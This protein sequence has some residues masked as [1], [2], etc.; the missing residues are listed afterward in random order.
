[1]HTQFRV[2]G[3]HRV[4]NSFLFILLVFLSSSCSTPPR[5]DEAGNVVGQIVKVVDGDTVQLTIG[6]KR[7]TV[8][9]IGVDTPETKHPTKPVECWGPEAAAFTESV[10]PPGT[11]VIVV[12]DEQARDKYGRLLAY[13]YRRD[14]KIFI[15]RELVSGG[16]A[17]TLTIPPNTAY[18]TVFERDR[19][20]SQ[21]AQLGLWRHCRR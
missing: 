20:S 18:E 8:R 12:R 1:M 6:G 16:W 17:D 13:L 21:E 5:T 4:A 15:N 7:E 2:G 9:L 3:V 11:T 10:L 14:D 19:L